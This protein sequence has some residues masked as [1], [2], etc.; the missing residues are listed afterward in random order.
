VFFLPF[1]NGA[2]DELHARGSLV[3][4]STWHRLGHA[5]RAVY[6][7]VAF[8]HRRHFERLLGVSARPGSA[9]FAGGPVRSPEW[10]A[11]FAAAL[12]LTLDVPKGEEFGARGAAIL[13]AV[14][15]G[16]FPDIAVAV[17]AMTALARRIEPDAGLQAL[18]DR[19]YAVYNQLH[20]TL[21]PYWQ[22]AET[23]LTLG[24]MPR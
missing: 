22:A 20:E 5:V 6:E 10:A 3:G 21:R 16:H 15:A 2:V 9:R 11:I 1:L 7:G 18:L 12:G 4:F 8:E 14:A 19:R 17:A 13:A 24:K 23:M